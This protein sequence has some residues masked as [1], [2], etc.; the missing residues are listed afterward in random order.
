MYAC[1]LQYS[2]VLPSANNGM[3]GMFQIWVIAI[4]SSFKTFCS[5]SQRRVDFQNEKT[6]WFCFTVPYLCLKFFF[7]KLHCFIMFCFPAAFVDNPNHLLTCFLGEELPVV[8][9]GP[10]GDCLP[11]VVGTPFLHHNFKSFSLKRGATSSLFFCNCYCISV[12]LCTLRRTTIVSWCPR[13][14]ALGRF[15]PRPRAACRPA[16]PA[17]PPPTWAWGAH[18]PPTRPPRPLSTPTSPALDTLSASWSI[19]IVSGRL[20][21]FSRRKQN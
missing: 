11:R 12:I 7:L 1:I 20:Q 3:L 21:G 19:D 4:L 8:P 16:W 14:A 18:P 9:L 17:P 2:I 15:L 6:V 10:L 5:R 13:K